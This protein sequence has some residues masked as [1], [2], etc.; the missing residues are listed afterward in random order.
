MGS[1]LTDLDQA[2]LFQVAHLAADR[3]IG[4]HLK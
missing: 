4:A 3:A 1:L 2:I